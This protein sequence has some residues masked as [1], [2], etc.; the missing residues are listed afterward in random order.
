MLNNDQSYNQLHIASLNG[1]LDAVTKWAALMDI[2]ATAS[3]DL[4]TPLMMACQMGHYEIVRTLLSLRADVHVRDREGHTALHW[5]ALKL[6][7]PELLTL[8]IRAG[9]EVNSQ[10]E[11]GLT[12]LCYAAIMG[13]RG[14]CSILMDSGADRTIVCRRWTAEQLARQYGHL[15]I[16]ESIAGQKP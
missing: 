8:L 6:D 7:Q 15:D 13:F 12:P 5:A 3:D 1:D 2:N 11:V 10:T 14:N 9:A 16:A 4:H